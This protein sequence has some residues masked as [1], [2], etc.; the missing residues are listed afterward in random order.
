[1]ALT[2]VNA[3]QSARPLFHRTIFF[4]AKIPPTFFARWRAR[5]KARYNS[6]LVAPD[7]TPLFLLSALFAPHFFASQGFS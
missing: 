3:V 6:S 7:P 5:R 4:G 1:L 2:G